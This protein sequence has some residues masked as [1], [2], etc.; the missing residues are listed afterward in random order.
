M[1]NRRV[2]AAGFTLIELL[3]TLSLI[4]VLLGLAAPSLS[5][6]FLNNKLTG[7]TNSFSAAI[8]FSR[9]EAVKRN[10]VVRMCRRERAS[11]PA[12]TPTCSTSGNWQKGWFVWVDAN[13]DSSL[14]A[15]EILSE[16]QPLSSDYSFTSSS[17][18]LAFQ[19]SGIGADTD[20]FTLCHSAGESRRQILL[21]STGRTKVVKDTAST[22]P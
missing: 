17:Y 13:G 10:A 12:G 2:R 4:A 6:V 22:C 11:E 18:S 8:L 21:Y 1:A 20:T 19:A 3:V 14:Q 16:Q 7:Y 9:G 5:A 15:D